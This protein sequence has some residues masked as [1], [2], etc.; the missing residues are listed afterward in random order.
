MSSAASTPVPVEKPA[1]YLP[2][3]MKKFS[4]IF[5]KQAMMWTFG[6]FA[7]VLFP[8]AITLLVFNAKLN[9]VSFDY[10]ECYALAGTTLAAPPSNISGLPLDRLTQ[11]ITRWSYNPTSKNC[12]IEFSIPFTIATTVHMYIGITNFYQNQQYYVKSKDAGQLSGT[13]YANAADVP[14]A[15][16][17]SS[18]SCGW[19]LY[20][21]C[22]VNNQ[23]GNFGTSQLS[24]GTHNPDC[25]LGNTDPVVVNAQSTAQYYPCGLIA[26]SMFSGTC[27][28]GGLTAGLDTIG[29]LLCQGSSCRIPTYT[30]TQS[31][32]AWPEDSSLYA[33]TQWATGSAEQ[34]ASIPTKLIPPPM[35]RK[36]WPDIWGSG[37]NASNLPD[38][39]RWERF[40]VWMRTAA[41][42][43]FRKLWGRNTNDALDAG[44]YQMTITNNWDAVRFGGTKSIVFSDIGIIG[45]RND[46]TAIVFLVTACLCLVGFV[47]VSILNP[48]KMGDMDR[49]SWKK[50]Q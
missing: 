24:Y 7:L 32:I 16:S 44:L 12:T 40:Q 23:Q 26:N 21:N 2:E 5:D 11:G 10:T 13:L 17:S 41:L 35:W 38:L 48:R 46:F 43:S 6:A 4:L 42:P 3:N 18:T 49:V 50:E 34:Q 20:A 37:Y 14:S 8:L 1:K 28:A 22:A 29:D 31:G 36:A 27:S 15:A 9:T 30:F 19:L 45:P 25:R 39:A 33:K 47:V